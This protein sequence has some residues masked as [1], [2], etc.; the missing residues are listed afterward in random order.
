MKKSMALVFI[1]LGLTGLTTVE[2]QEKYDTLNLTTSPSGLQYRISREGKGTRPVKGDRVWLHYIGWLENDSIF[3]S[4]IDYGPVD[5]Y[6]GQG[7]VTKAWEEAIPMM[8]EGG[9][10]LLKVPPYLGYGKQEMLGVPANSTLMFEIALVQVDAGEPIKPYAVSGKG[11]KIAKGLRMLSLKEGNGAYVRPGDNAYINYTGFIDDSVIFASSI[12]GKPVRLTVG[13]NQ[14][15]EGVDAAL[16]HMKPGAKARLLMSPAYAYGAE[17]YS[18]WVPANTPV[19]MDVELLRVVPEIKVEQWDVRGL[20]KQTTASGLSYYIVEEGEGD[21]IKAQNIVQM[22]YSG[23]LA[24]GT[25]FDSSVKRDEPFRMPVG[26]GALIEGWEE[27]L[28]K[29]KPGAKFQLHIPAKL[30]YGE[31]GSPPKVPAHADLILDVEILEVF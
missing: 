23:Y 1:M 21:L 7:Q 29:M 14:L 26:I 5:V 17:G 8:R 24:D 4:S 2:A 25:V 11:K 15:V 13:E 10:I 31:A 27:G 19:I 3:T 16:L 9:N 6:L 12:H 28:L 22:H 30:G 20:E 18:T